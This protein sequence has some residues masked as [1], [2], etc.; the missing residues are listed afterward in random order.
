MYSIDDLRTFIVIAETGGVTAGARRVGVSPATASHR[1]SKLEAALRL[2]LF[3]RNSRTLRLT[4][5]GQVFF[6]RV[7]PILADLS[8]AERDAGSGAAELSGNLRITMSPWILSR[9]I[10]PLLPE[11]QRKHPKLTFEFLAV[12]RYVSLAAEGQD[13]AIRVGQLED[14][15]LLARKLSDN[16]RIICCAPGFLDAHGPFDPLDRL[17]HAPWVSLPWQRRL[18]VKDARGR[19]KTLTTPKSILVSNSD[20][21]TESAVQGL[22][23]A[24]KSR[25]AVKQELDAGRL[26]EVSSGT[27]WEPSA[28][29]WFV[30]PPEARSGQKTKL[31][32]DLA[33]R[34]FTQSGLSDLGSL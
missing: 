18:V 20:M 12:D 17:I 33:V 6:E 23:L 8:K 30:F 16:R 19:K 29:I 14:S 4:P 9:F 28:P 34:A 11:F 7:Q 2:T 22:G 3:H 15:A 27:L 13:C 31:F 21:L 10:M 25:L 5:E 26:V 1:L 32:G 24:I